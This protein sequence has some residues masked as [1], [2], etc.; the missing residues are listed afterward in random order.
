MGSK[1][2]YIPRVEHRD[3]FHAQRFCR[4]IVQFDPVEAAMF[5]IGFDANNG[6]VEPAAI[7]M[8]LYTVANPVIVQIYIPRPLSQFR[9]WSAANCHV[10]S[11]ITLCA[12]SGR[13]IASV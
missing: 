4:F 3:L 10:D 1:L 12:V 2:S 5:G 11:S 6:A 9:T 7:K 13:K 8:D